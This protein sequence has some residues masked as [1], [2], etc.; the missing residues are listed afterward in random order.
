MRVLLSAL[1]ASFIAACAT[2]APHQAS[3][4]V[5]PATIAEL[6]AANAAFSAA[7]LANDVDAL[8]GAYAEDAIAHPPPGGVLV[9]PETIRPLWDRPRNPNLIG[10]RLEP[11][12]RRQLAPG[13]VLEMG[14]WHTGL[15]DDGEER[16]S[17]GCYSVIW[18]DS[19]E[20]WR[21]AY[22]GWTAANENDWAC[23][24]R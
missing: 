10:H 3:S 21:F 18:R 15:N 11:M 14:R 13:L 2:A 7:L 24:P 22:D 12:L 1:C 5:P 23:R 17:S 4:A 20:G 19:A 9:S 16:W 8:V 6:D